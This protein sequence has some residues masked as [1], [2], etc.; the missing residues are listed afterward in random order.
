MFFFQIVSQKD[1]N[2]INVVGEAGGQM[3]FGGIDKGIENSLAIA[4]DIWP[5]PGLDKV[6][7][8]HYL[9]FFIFL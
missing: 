8:L 7:H 1:P 9:T 3:G 4:F 2:T 6:G 5:N